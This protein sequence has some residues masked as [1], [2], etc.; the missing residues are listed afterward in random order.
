MKITL[1][2]KRAW[3]NNGYSGI[4][5]AGFTESGDIIEFNSNNPGAIDHEVFPSATSFDPRRCED[6][7]LGVK[8]YQGKVTRRELTPE[9]VARLN[10]AELE[11][12]D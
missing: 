6:I 10:E 5:Y 11:E 3:K 2:Q 9:Q 8:V 12:E 1:I 4:G 7:A